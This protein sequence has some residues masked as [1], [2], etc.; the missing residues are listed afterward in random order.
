MTTWRNLSECPLGLA[1]SASVVNR[2]RALAAGG[3]V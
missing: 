2:C 1:V 3:L